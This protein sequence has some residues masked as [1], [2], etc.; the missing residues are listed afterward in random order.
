M[1]EG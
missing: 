1:P